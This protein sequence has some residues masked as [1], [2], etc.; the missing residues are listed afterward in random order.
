MTSEPPLLEVKNLHTQFD[1]DMGTVKAVDGVSFE[2]E[3]GETFGI[4]GESGAGKSVTGLSILRLIDSPGRIVEGEILFEGEDLLSMSTEKLREI[5]GNKIAMIFQD[6][7]TSLNPAFTVGEQIIDTI[8]EHTE[9]SKK[10]ARERTITILEDVGIPDAKSRVDDYP[11]QFSG[12]MRQRVLIGMAIS[13]EPDLLIADEPTTALD[14]T[15]QSQIL[16]LLS[17]LQEQYG[18]AIQIITHNMGVIAQT[19]DRVGVMYAGKMVEEGPTKEIFEKPQHPY[20][21]GLM[22]AIPRL[23]DP[24]SRLETIEGR[25]P[26]LIETP[27]GCSFHPR[28]PYAVEECKLEEPPLE[29]TDSQVERKSACIRTKDIDFEAEL[30]VKA[31]EEQSTRSIDGENILEVSDIK[32]YFTPESQS[33]YEQWFNPKY[34]RAVDGVSLNIKEGETLGLVGESGCG[35]STLGHTLLQLYEPDGGTVLYAGEDISSMKKRELREKRS[36]LQLIFQ[37]P[38][39]SL[40]PRKT[41]KQIIGRPMEIH[42]DFDSEEEKTER[43]EELLVEVGLSRDQ[44][45][46]YPH[47]FSGGQKQR[48]GIARALAVEPDFIVA[49]EPVSALDV[50]VQAKITNLLMDL[51][52]EY[53]LTYLFIAHDLNVIQHISDRIAVMYLGEI[54]EIGTVDE[55]FKPPYHPYTEIL[56]TSIPRPDPTIE[57]ERVVPKGEPPSPIDPPSGCKFHTRCPYAIEECKEINPENIEVSEGHEIHCHLFDEEVMNGKEELELPDEDIAAQ[58]DD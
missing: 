24:R 31:T 46:R 50:S 8:L 43:I 48:I 36:D 10:E 6:P 49:D 9:L 22:K 40:N 3:S 57:Q 56:L 23:D 30:T 27:S 5:R 12:G 52:E 35:K 45:N 25:M 2:I 32:K 1:T 33:W 16:E 7:M 53:N 39:S 38:F 58:S 34:V 42:N 19:S 29:Q 51:Q 21:L 55:I 41:V 18:L 20:T 28:C 4:V 15:I 11:H 44:I 13:C 47:E 54:A 26:D 37:D 14:V 17:D